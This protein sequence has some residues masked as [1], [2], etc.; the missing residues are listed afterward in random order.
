VTHLVHELVVN[1]DLRLFIRVFNPDELPQV[2]PALP[3]P[4][5]LGDVVL[6]PVKACHQDHKAPQTLDLL[7]QGAEGLQF[8]THAADGLDVQGCMKQCRGSSKGA[9]GL[10]QVIS[11]GVQTRHASLAGILTGQLKL[12]D[13]CQAQKAPRMHSTECCLHTQHS[14]MCAAPFCRVYPDNCESKGAAN[15]SAQATALPTSLSFLLSTIHSSKELPSTT[16]LAVDH[17]ES[18]RDRWAPTGPMGGLLNRRLHDKSR[19]QQ[20]Q[21]V[22]HCIRMLQWGA[23][24]TQSIFD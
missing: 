4:L 3:Q 14:T 24:L 5:A 15:Y 19:Q 1:D 9:V 7:L 6:L 2:V 8:K 22:T 23:Q 21:P 20:E 13:I 10:W 17:L 11:V 12:R 18:V 16:S